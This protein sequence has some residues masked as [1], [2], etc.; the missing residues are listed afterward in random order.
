MINKVSPKVFH[1]KETALSVA[2]VNMSFVIDYWDS[3]TKKFA[4]I[5][6]DT[7]N[8]VLTEKNIFEKE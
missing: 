6:K 1:N 7:D 2:N 4:F 3:K 8:K 5:V